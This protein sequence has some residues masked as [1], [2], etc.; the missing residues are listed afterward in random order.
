MKDFII[1][2]GMCNASKKYL[3]DDL[4]SDKVH[5]NSKKAGQIPG[6]KMD[7]KIYRNGT[8]HIIQCIWYSNILKNAKR[9]YT[10]KEYSPEKYH[11][12]VD[13]EIVN[14]DYINDIPDYDGIMGVPISIIVYPQD[15]FEILGKATNTTIEVDGKRINKFER[16]LIKKK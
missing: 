9:A 11:K 6:S 5:I 1:V 7:F 15:Q 14:V 10:F 2:G 4:V 13:T 3:F 8:D 16:I 12:Y